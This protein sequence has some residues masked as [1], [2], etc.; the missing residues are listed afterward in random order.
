MVASPNLKPGDPPSMLRLCRSRFK[1][2]VYASNGAD[3]NKF[4]VAP[5]IEL[6]KKELDPFVP[7]RQLRFRL[8]DNNNFATVGAYFSG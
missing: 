4:Q 2:C 8:S 6:E 3:L 1:Y 5:E 7:R